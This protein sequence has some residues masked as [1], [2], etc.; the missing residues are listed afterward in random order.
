MVI[1]MAIHFLLSAQAR[2]L[3]VYKVIQMT[4]EQAFIAFKEIRWGAGEQVTC[5]H[6][7]VTE[8]HYFIRGRQQWRCQSCNHTFSVT[9][10]TIF[11]FHKLPLKV[12]LAA[13]VRYLVI[14]WP[15]A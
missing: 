2:T 3:A 4:K 12:Y 8:K 14:F 6:C 13:I 7:Q 5:P 15:S 10:G 11:A 9:S 1:V